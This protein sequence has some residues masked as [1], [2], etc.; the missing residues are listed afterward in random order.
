MINFD[1]YHPDKYPLD[2][3]LANLISLE[4]AQEWQIVPLRKNGQLLTIATTESINIKTL[5]G[6]KFKTGCEVDPVI[7]TEQELKQ[8]IKVLYGQKQLSN[9]G[10]VYALLNPSFQGLIKIGKTTREIQSRINELSSTGVP[11]PFVL[12]HSI[13]VNDCSQAENMIHI[14][15][16]EKNFRVT[17]DREFFNAPLKLVIDLMES[18]KEEI[19]YPN[20]I[21]FEAEDKIDHYS[22][23]TLL[24]QINQIEQNATDYLYGENGKLPD[25]EK[26]LA[27]FEKSANLG[28]AFSYLQMAMIYDPINE[29][30]SRVKKNMNQQIKYLLKC[31]ELNNDY[32]SAEACETLA[33]IYRNELQDPAKCK[34]FWEKC[35]YH[36][37]QNFDPVML[38]AKLNKNNYLRKFADYM[39]DMFEFDM[40]INKSLIFCEHYDEFYNDLISF[41]Q[42]R[43]NLYGSKTNSILKAIEFIRQG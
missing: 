23:N 16:E 43:I 33:F 32:Y 24:E 1:R 31:A 17:D 20:V 38:I 30:S 42:K 37:I 29:E 40:P 25:E 39:I 35:L 21:R 15:L 12:A 3:N 18:V 14:L 6:I 9:P 8:L 10:Y 7:C 13:Y 27:L 28:S 26:A 36:A 41:L 22:K 5:D 19:G 4:M 34:I 11:I 2:M